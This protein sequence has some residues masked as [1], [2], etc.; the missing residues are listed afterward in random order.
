[1]QVFGA[2]MVG[3]HALRIMTGCSYF[4]ALRLR[5]SILTYV[6]G[7]HDPDMLLA[8]HKYAHTTFVH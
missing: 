1:M 7:L 5:L 2:H 6:I 8:Y 3:G 4:I